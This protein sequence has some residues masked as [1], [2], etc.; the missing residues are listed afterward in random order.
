MHLQHTNEKEALSGEIGKHVALGQ[1]KDADIADLKNKLN[2]I[3]GEL[4]NSQKNHQ[5]SANEANLWRDKHGQS[6]AD[7][8]HQLEQARQLRDATVDKLSRNHSIEK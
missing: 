6:E 1:Q 5:N 7:R 3:L 4:A 2:G 8:S